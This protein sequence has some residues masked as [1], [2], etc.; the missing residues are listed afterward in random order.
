MWAS[1]EAKDKAW[2]W[3]ARSKDQFL[4][5]KTTSYGTTKISKEKI[6]VHFEGKP[7][8]AIFGV[9]ILVHFEGKPCKAMFGVEIFVRFGG[10]KPCKAIFGVEYSGISDF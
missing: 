1:K 6:F 9:E 4:Y 10:E 7:C 5:C 8:K 3:Q 2:A